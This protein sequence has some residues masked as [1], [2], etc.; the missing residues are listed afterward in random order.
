[1][2][3][4]M[5]YVECSQCGGAMFTDYYYKS[6]EEYWICK[7]CG[8]HGKVELVRDE[9]R[10][11]IFDERGNP[12]YC[13]EDVASFGCAKITIKGHGASLSCFN[14]PITEED[15]QA[16]FKMLEDE[17]VDKEQ[18]YL[19]FWNAETGKVEMIYGQDPKL[20]GEDEDL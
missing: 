7:R 15:K 2:G 20:Y 16:F 4:V 13:E 5:D 8:K 3:S 14:K 18:S 12:K 9:E 1:M 6:G 11:V 10:N 19:S 17:K